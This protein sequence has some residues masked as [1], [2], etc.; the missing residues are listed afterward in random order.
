MIIYFSKINLES[1]YLLEMYKEEEKFN[2]IRK[3]ILSFLENGVIYETEG[4]FKA[5]G[6]EV[7]YTKT[8]YRLSIGLKDD[9]YISGVVYKSTVLYYKRLNEVTEEVESHGIPTIEDVRFYFDINRE[10]VGFHTRHRFGYQEFNR[11]FA[12][13]LNSCMKKNNS[14][15]KFT[16]SLYNEGME[17]T[18]LEQELKNINNIK[19]L[20]F[21]FK[22]PNPADSRMLKRLNDGLTDTAE[23]MEE[24]NACSKSVIFDSDGNVGLNID[25]DEI[26]ENINR[27][28]HLTKGVSD[29]E[30]LQN[31]YVRVVATAKDGKIYT[32]EEQRPIKRETISETAEEFFWACRDTILNI[33]SKKNHPDEER[34]S[35]EI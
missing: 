10:I 4:N 14:P 22:L 8:N 16:V 28:G 3:S 5:D 35:D 32:T 23:L 15:L 18:E 21:R 33:F 19:R 1:T 31:G 2:N 13:I 20:E 17:I 6:G 30:A 12:G 7:H 34:T 27:V 26:R 24:A 25:S 29:K 9:N 11:A